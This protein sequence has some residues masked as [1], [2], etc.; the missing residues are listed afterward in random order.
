MASIAFHPTTVGLPT[1]WVVVVVLEPV[2]LNV[3]AG[4]VQHQINGYHHEWSLIEGG[5]DPNKPHETVDEA[6]QRLLDS[7]ADIGPVEF[8]VATKRPL[9]LARDNNTRTSGDAIAL[10]QDKAVHVLYFLAHKPQPR[11]EPKDGDNV[12]GLKFSQA[13]WIPPQDICERLDAGASLE[14][15]AFYSELASATGIVVSAARQW[16]R[17]R[18]AKLFRRAAKVASEKQHINW[19]Y[20]LAKRATLR[21]DYETASRFY[22]EGNK[23]VEAETRH[24][25]PGIR[26]SV[27]SMAAGKLPDYLKWRLARDDGNFT[28]ERGRPFSAEGVVEGV[29]GRRSSEAVLGSIHDSLLEKGI[30]T[31]YYDD[32]A[33]PANE[34]PK[35]HSAAMSAVVS[36]SVSRRPNAGIIQ[37]FADG[38]RAVLRL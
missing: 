33:A 20:T 18:A 9:Y 10:G 17:L 22:L 5:R 29:Y 26:S 28:T 8:L 7:T 1:P 12:S 15:V 37:K 14:R 38:L 24:V 23:L 16:C 32:D 31:N 4:G 11:G 35:K 3:F 36:G 6:A 34:A 2:A 13:Q 19:K 21:G 25:N 30:Y 27:T